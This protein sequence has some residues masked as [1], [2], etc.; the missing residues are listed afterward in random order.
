LQ[1]PFTVAKADA[2]SSPG[3]VELY[4]AARRQHCAS[5]TLLFI[6]SS[7][8][9][10][11]LWLHHL[12]EASNAKNSIRRFGAHAGAGSYSDLGRFVLRGTDIASA[13][14]AYVQRREYSPSPLA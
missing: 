2:R 3:G 7:S 5:G 9:G 11:H 14:A 4:I 8:K 1:L 6:I 10:V 13:G 12:Q